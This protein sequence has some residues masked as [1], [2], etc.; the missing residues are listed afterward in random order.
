[1]AEKV[2]RLDLL[3]SEDNGSGRRPKNGASIRFISDKNRPIPASKMRDTLWK[4]CHQALGWI[5][6]PIGVP[7]TDYTKQ[8]HAIEYPVGENPGV[9][10]LCGKLDFDSIHDYAPRARILDLLRRSGVDDAEQLTRWLEIELGPEEA[11]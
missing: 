6:A 1:M 9:C 5:G 11:K 4:H 8:P 2:Y 3:V 10:G 7:L